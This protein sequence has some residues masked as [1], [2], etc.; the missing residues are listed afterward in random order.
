MQIAII[1]AGKMGRGIATRALAGNHAV[2]IIDR[3]KDR[4]ARIAAEMRDQQPGADIQA[5]GDEAI[6]AAGIVVLALKYPITTQVAAR[7]AGALDGKVVIDMA[8]PAN[9]DTYDPATST[10][11]S[12]AEELASKIPGAR[13][14]KAFNTIFAASLMDGRADGHSL[15]L[16]IASDDARARKAVAEFA[17][18]AGLHPIDVGPL[19]H[20][21][22]LEA[23]Q[24][25][26]MSLQPDMPSPWRSAIK[27]L[28]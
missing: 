22:A 4:G 10:G 20:A 1:G 9:W 24:I 16:F 23:F 25:L 3:D 19:R 2:R 7:Y 18:S 21:R 12:A 8:N 27:I 13:V 5:G 26:H 11:T 14:V 28:D 17:T 15:D 6:A